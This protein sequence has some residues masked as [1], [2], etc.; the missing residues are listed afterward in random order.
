[1]NYR[2]IGTSAIGSM[3][4]LPIKIKKILGSWFLGFQTCTFYA[5]NIYDI[6]VCMHVPPINCAI[7]PMLAQW[8]CVGT[9][10]LPHRGGP[11]GPYLGFSCQSL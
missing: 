3:Y 8:G 11:T 9:R 10:G 1:M 7:Y 4:N 2:L 5:L 6:Y